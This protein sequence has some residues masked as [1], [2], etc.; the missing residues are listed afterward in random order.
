MTPSV[1]KPLPT[2]TPL[3]APFWRAARQGE[4]R[5]Q[6]CCQCRHIRYPISEVCPE[7]LSEESEW[8]RL[9]GRGTVFS[10]VTFHQVYHPAYR[11]EV[12][13]NVSIIQ[14][15]EGPRMISNVVDIAVDQVAIGQKV[16]V[17]FD[18]VSDTVALPRFRPPGERT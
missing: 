8:A 15:D 7:C 13:Y 18:P 14:L 11:D 6:Q 1:E 3:N 10:F 2:I 9:S 16:E 5:L 17:C 12:P 4:L